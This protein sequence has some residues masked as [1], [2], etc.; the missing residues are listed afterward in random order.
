[1][2]ISRQPVKGLF[3]TLLTLPLA[4]ALWLLLIEGF[5]LAYGA[6][7][8]VFTVCFTYFWHVGWSLGGW[9]GNLVTE[10]RWARGTINWILLMLLV[11]LTV[12]VWGWVYDL[13]FEETPLGLW[14]QTTI[15][16][17]VACVFFFGNQLLLP[18]ELGSKQPLAGLTNLMFCLSA[19][20]A[21]FFIPLMW[22][23]A[24]GFLPF[25]WFPVALVFMAYFGGWPFDQLGQPRAGLAYLAG[26][27]LVTFLMMVI[28]DEAGIDFFGNELEAAKATI[29]AATWTNVG[30]LMAWH[31]NM[32]PIGKWAQPWKGLAGTA[33]TVG[34]S[35][36][37]YAAV[38][39]WVA[40]ADLGKA[41]F[42]EFAFMW[43]LVSFSGVGLFDGFSM[44]Y[45]DDPGGAGPEPR[46]A[47]RAATPETAATAEGQPR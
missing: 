40:E 26:V 20:F 29:W 19:A 23:S 33:I 1:M 13:P 17:G 25:V 16:A 39:G 9:P 47:A 15:I 28:L 46:G 2:D 35:L 22:G 42:A 45:E 21:V 27:F 5:G 12:A 6:G 34:A 3:L 30:L 14:A 18:E 41:I 7:A 36:L 4:V 44:G 37:V 43:A 8:V 10:N 38:V 11:W 31:F 32:W 24:P